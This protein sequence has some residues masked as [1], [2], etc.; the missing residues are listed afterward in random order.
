MKVP[1]KVFAHAFVQVGKKGGHVFSIDAVGALKRWAVQA[2]LV[3]TPDAEAMQTLGVAGV[4]I[5]AP[6]TVGGLDMHLNCIYGKSGT[7]LFRAAALLRID[8][9]VS[10]TT[11]ARLDDSWVPSMMANMPRFS[12]Q[13]ERPLG[14]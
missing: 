4:L 13:R 14:H 9:L 11:G 10:R 8:Q 1:E 2:S 3:S 5:T 12:Q 6:P 7:G